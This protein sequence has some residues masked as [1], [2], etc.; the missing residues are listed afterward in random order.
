MAA[1]SNLWRHFRPGF[2][3]YCSKFVVFDQN[4]TLL[5][6]KIKSKVTIGPMVMLMGTM[7]PGLGPHVRH[8]GV[9]RPKTI[10]KP[11]ALKKVIK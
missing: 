5:A 3:I 11:K 8:E 10:L 6:P 1:I 2:P 7:P 9:G 4:T